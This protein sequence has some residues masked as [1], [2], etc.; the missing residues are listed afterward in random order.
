MVTEFVQ[1]NFNTVYSGCVV[2][3]VNTSSVIIDQAKVIDRNVCQK[4]GIIFFQT[5][6][7]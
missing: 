2:M 7:L 3:N 5:H 6:M 4:K 1:E